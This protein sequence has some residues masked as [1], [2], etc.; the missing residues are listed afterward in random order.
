[1]ADL[2]ELT[3][4][5]TA[6]WDESKPAGT[7]DINLGDDDIREMKGQERERQDVDHQRPQS[8]AGI[9]NIG[10]HK[11]IHL[12]VQTV[13]ASLAD[14]GCLYTKDVNGKAE[15]HFMDEDT[16]EIALTTAGKLKLGSTY[17][18]ETGIAS[19]KYIKYDGTKFVLD[20]PV[21]VVAGI[22]TMWSGL[23]NA[24]PSGW[25]ICDGNNGTPNLTDKFIVGASNVAAAAAPTTTFTGGATTS[26]GSATHTHSV[27]RDG[28]GIS[29]SAP[30][31][32]RLASGYQSG[33]DVNSAY[34][35]SGDNT[36]G[37]N[38]VPAVPYYALAF[39][40]KT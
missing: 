22:I 5:S 20:T 6:A 18:D 29:Y 38:N 31:T 4:L 3:A 23:M 13:I 12:L 9:K 21:G 40:M 35:V 30:S 27:S 33:G 24:I 19:G 16:N 1:M 2:S 25:V 36:T 14:A 39:I 28:W 7:R 26:G 8:E 15:L 37:N 10:A 34:N 11:I 32:G 17:L